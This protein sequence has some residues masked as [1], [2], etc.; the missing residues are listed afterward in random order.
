MWGFE[1]HQDFVS[2]EDREWMGSAL[3]GE[4]L[5]SLLLKRQAKKRCK[6]LE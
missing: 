6:S 2:F 5:G 1:G 3:L 4:L